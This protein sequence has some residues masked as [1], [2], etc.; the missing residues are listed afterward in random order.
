MKGTERHR[1]RE[2]NGKRSSI[3]KPTP[4]E[5]IHFCNEIGL[6][7]FDAELRRCIEQI[8][9]PSEYDSFLKRLRQ[10][11]YGSIE[12]RL[13]L[14]LSMWTQAA[15]VAADVLGDLHVPKKFRADPRLEFRWRRKQ[16]MDLPESLRADV[17]LRWETAFDIGRP[18]AK[19]D[20]L[21]TWWDRRRKLADAAKKRSP[22]TNFYATGEAR[23]IKTEHALHTEFQAFGCP[24]KPLD[25]GI[26][27]SALDQLLSLRETWTKAR[28]A[29]RQKKSRQ[30]Q[31]S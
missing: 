21:R 13:R 18:L 25:D 5:L 4:A 30:P 15:E 23:D 1:I 24:Q 11:G 6:D 16:R 27:V 17:R 10:Q 8:R 22:K 29:D 26:T 20:L 9:T 14:G 12:D 3:S 31:A 7:L 28:A 2:R 19:D